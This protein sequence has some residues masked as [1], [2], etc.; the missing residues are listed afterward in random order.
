MALC[1]LLFHVG[2]RTPGEL[3]TPTGLSGLLW[4]NEYKGRKGLVVKSQDSVPTMAR[5]LPLASPLHLSEP[6]PYL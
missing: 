1:L 4:E 6:I 3:L 5:D 2:H